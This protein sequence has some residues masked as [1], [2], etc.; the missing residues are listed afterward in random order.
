MNKAHCTK[1]I[2]LQIV[3]YTE[4]NILSSYN[5]E[6]DDFKT[7]FE[8]V[9]I[10]KVITLRLK[11]HTYLACVAYLLT[12]EGGPDQHSHTVEYHQLTIT[13]G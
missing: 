12:C 1:N 2:Q 11:S 13:C 8:N 3:G 10:E 7:E 4:E 5:T 9:T 6:G